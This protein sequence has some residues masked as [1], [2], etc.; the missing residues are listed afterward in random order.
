MSIF[1]N[2]LN[3]VDV[4]EVCGLS[5]ELKAIYISNIFTNSKQNILFVTNSLYE[6]NKM[7]QVISNYKEDVFL[8][9]MDDFLTS[10]ALATSPELKINRL[11]TIK[12]LNGNKKSIIV[13][14]LMGLLRY[15][16]SKKLFSDKSLKLKVGDNY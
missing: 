16:P 6:A 15:L 9:P 3:N 8:F 12:Q 2:I 14:N 10:E 4:E 13:T 11:E 1:E 5:N 7:Y